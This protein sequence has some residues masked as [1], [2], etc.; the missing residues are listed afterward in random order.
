[1]VGGG[2]YQN[3]KFPGTPSDQTGPDRPPPSQKLSSTLADYQD[4]GKVRP[5][6]ANVEKTMTNTV[7]TFAQPVRIALAQLDG[8]DVHA[9]R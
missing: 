3:S 9:P 5:G 7:T 4:N 6:Q 2:A 8:S 1:M